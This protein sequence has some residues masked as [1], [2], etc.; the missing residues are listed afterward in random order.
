MG[1]ARRRLLVVTGVVSGLVA[2][3]LCDTDTM[4]VVEPQGPGSEGG[5]RAEN[6]GAVVELSSDGGVLGR[7]SRTYRRKC[8][9]ENLARDV[10][11]L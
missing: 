3:N 10:V 2:E 8:P 5:G 4:S 11:I 1:D 6:L 7:L 9:E